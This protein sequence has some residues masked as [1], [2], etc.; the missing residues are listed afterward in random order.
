[1]AKKRKKIKISPLTQLI[2]PH[3]TPHNAVFAKKHGREVFGSLSAY[4]NTLIANDRKAK[5]TL[6]HWGPKTE[7]MSSVSHDSLKAKSKLARKS[8]ARA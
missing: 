2:Q 4:I 3:V 7:K 6:G 1:M 8:E 5:P